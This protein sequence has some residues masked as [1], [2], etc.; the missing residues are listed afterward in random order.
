[1]QIL[2]YFLSIGQE[3]DMALNI[4]GFNEVVFCSNNNRLNVDI[5]MPSAQHFLPMKDLMDSSTVTGE[6]L[7]SM[8]KIHTLKKDLDRVNEKL[9]HTPLASLYLIYASYGKYLYKKYRSRLV[10]FDTLIKPA[11]PGTGD[12]IVNIK[13]TPAVG[14]EPVLLAGVATLWYRTSFIMSRVMTG[15]GA[16]YYHFLQPNQYYSEKTFSKEE[17]ETA[18]DQQLAYNILVKKGYP[19]LQKAVEALQANHVNAFSAVGI[20]D[21]VKETV[22][23]DKCCHFNRLG[24]ELFADFIAHSIIKE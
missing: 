1:M 20:F 18:L 6:K 16:R 13:Y 7:E 9:I 12:S 17:R 22:Y 23:I 2:T 14:D 15:R 21:S 19:V 5:A 11:K 24:N 10:Q 4:D 3:L 8:W